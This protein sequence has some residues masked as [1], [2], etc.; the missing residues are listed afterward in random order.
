MSFQQQL[1]QYPQNEILPLITEA[2]PQRIE[3]ALQRPRMTM[4]DFASL[5]SPQ[6][7]DDQLERM[8]IRAHNITSQRFGRTILLYRSTCRM[9]VITAANTAVSAPTI[10][11]CVKR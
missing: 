6:I 3:Q 11:C 2:T 4:E 7:S 8:A 1:E 10:S 5:L 9:N